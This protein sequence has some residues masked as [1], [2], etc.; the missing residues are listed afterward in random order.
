[1][2]KD[3][4]MEILNEIA[5]IESYDTNNWGVYVN[6]VI[7]N[8]GFPK[9]DIRKMNKEKGIIGSGLALKEDSCDLLVEALISEG[10][11]C[12]SKILD[13][14]KKETNIYDYDIECKPCKK[15]LRI[16]I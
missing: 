3:I 16:R 15:V 7:W 10:Y 5:C 4:E 11:G 13:I 2:E 9:I 14:I 8:G 12:R 1:M 6:K